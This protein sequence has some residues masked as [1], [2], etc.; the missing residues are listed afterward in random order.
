[1]AV[2]KTSRRLR[3]GAATA[4]AAAL[5][6]GTGLTLPG[7]AHAEDVRGT[8]ANAGAEGTIPGS[9][10]VVLKEDTFSAASASAQ[11]LA[12]R[13]DAEVTSTFRHALNG[14]AAELSEDDARDLAADPAVA[15]VVQNTT[16]STTA[17][18]DTPPSWGQ[19]RL[20]QAEL[21][22]DGGFAYP[23]SAGE[24]VT[25][26][27]LDTGVR[28]SH[29]DFGDRARFGFDAF[30]QDGDDRNGHGTHVAGTVAGATYGVAKAADIVS[31]RVLDDRGKGSAETV[32]AG[33][34]FVARDATG[35]AVANLSL[36]GAGN[37]AL[38]AA[39]RNAIDAGVVFAVAA[40]NDYGAET[41]AYSPARVEE[42]VT[43]ASSTRDDK[44]SAFSNLGP[45]VDIFGPGTSIPS[46]WHTGDVAENTISG[47]SMA[48]PHVAGAAALHLADE[49]D[50]TPAEVSAALVDS[51]VWHRLDGVPA[52]TPN[53]LVHTGGQGGAPAPPDGPRFHSDEVAEIKDLST[54]ESVIEVADAGAVE[55]AW[56]VEFTIEHSYVGDLTVDVVAPDGTA[57]RLHNRSGGS[58]TE[59]HAVY[60]LHATALDAD[61]DWILRVADRAASDEGVLISWTLQL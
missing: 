37:S 56:E 11:V 53:A 19:D 51:A 27:I 41:G 16:V 12:Q 21:P 29:Q 26:Y 10:I 58:A 42:A 40:G 24:G 54:V 13:H 61:G 30:G 25:A 48:T 8:I 44:V 15:E 31:V 14:F 23:T 1:M 7:A 39:V 45:A 18:Q 55:G 17:S 6:L 32:I 3:T 46:A 2:M 47:T 59:L 36:G 43:V 28:Y 5:A 33:V 50:A 4:I 35:P 60:S 38:D 57:T 9:Y 22:L 52:G 20:D 34:D 49:P